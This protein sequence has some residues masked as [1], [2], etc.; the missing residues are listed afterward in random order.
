MGGWL[1]LPEGRGQI[2]IRASVARGR[3][4]QPVHIRV[5]RAFPH[6]RDPAYGW[7]TDFDEHDTERAGAVIEMRRVVERA[8]GRIVYEGETEVLGRRSSGRTEVTLH[9]PDR[10]EARVV[11]GPRTGS[12]THYHLVPDGA[13]CRLTVDYRFVLDD[14]RRQLLLRLAKPLVARELRKMWAGFADAMR[15]ELKT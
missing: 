10:W 1:S 9:P 6:A 15:S 2:A 13:G 7:L 14:P 5:E 11:S 3:V 8:P 4:A 12:F